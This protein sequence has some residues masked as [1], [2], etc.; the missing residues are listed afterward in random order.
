MYILQL[1]LRRLLLFVTTIDFHRGPLK[2]LLENI[3]SI[4]ESK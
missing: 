2:Y 1:H 4:K 3:L